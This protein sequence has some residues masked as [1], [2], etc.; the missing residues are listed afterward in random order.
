ME[1]KIKSLDKNIELP[2]YKHKG[3]AALDLRSAEEL[4]LNPNE[5]KIVKTAIKIAIPEGHAGLIWDR[6]GLAAKHSLHVFAGVVDSG[7]RVELWV[8]I[9]NLGKEEFKIEKNMRIAQIVIQP[10]VNANISEVEDL[11]ETSRNE[12][13]FGSS[14]HK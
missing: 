4:I 9:I 1:I 11:D 8:V 10:V 3:D 14:G 6:S 5:K 13:G 7:Y 2:H 12:K